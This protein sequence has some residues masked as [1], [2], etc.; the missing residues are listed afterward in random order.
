[1][2]YNYLTVAA[3]C[4]V[5]VEVDR[6]NGP[7]GKCLIEVKVGGKKLIMFCRSRGC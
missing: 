3:V 7:S 4:L 6:G 1:M 5:E 2:D